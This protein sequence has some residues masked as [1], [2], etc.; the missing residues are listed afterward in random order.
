MGHLSRKLGDGGF[1]LLIDNTAQLECLQII[2]DI[3]RYRTGLYVKIDTGYHR[4][5]LQP[6][7][8]ELEEVLAEIIHNDSGSCY[9]EGFYSHAGHSYG[10]DTRAK[11]MSH[12][13]KEIKDLLQAAT[14]YNSMPQAAEF[15]KQKPLVLSVGATPSATSIESLAIHT[16]V[17]VQWHREATE[18]RKDIDRCRDASYDLEIHAGVYPFLDMQQLATNASPSASD[19]SEAL[20]TE[21]IA[22]TVLGEVASVYS[23]RDAPEALITTGTLALGRE[24]CKSYNGWGRL[25]PWR[26]TAYEESGWIVGRITQEHGI[27]TRDPNITSQ[28]E[29]KVGDKLRIWPNHACIAGACYGWYLV[30]DSSLPESQR[31]MVVDV[32]VRWRGW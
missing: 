4:A 22:L 20:S 14:V 32:W 27:L 21:D 8:P 16:P 19:R 2:Y 28:C 7:S 15:L 17:N 11:A 24:P 29:L 31:D 6:D 13:S 10:V 23:G 26:T 5:G 25:S 12:L 18:L 30:V 3:S 1:S 9:L